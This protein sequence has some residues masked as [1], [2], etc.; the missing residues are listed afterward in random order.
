MKCWQW[1]VIHTSIDLS[2]LEQAAKWLT[3]FTSKA[4]CVAKL[5]IMDTRPV[6]GFGLHDTVTA[7]PSLLANTCVGFLRRFMTPQSAL[8]PISVSL[9]SCFEYHCLIITQANSLKWLLEHKIIKSLIY[10]FIY[11]VSTT[12]G[13]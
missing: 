13:R 3:G 8:L 12:F 2:H 10:Y 7:D 4:K 6:F 5:A 9:L 11:R 1:Y